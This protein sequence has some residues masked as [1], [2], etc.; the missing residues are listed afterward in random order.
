MKIYLKKQ[1]EWNFFLKNCAFLERF[2][3]RVQFTQKKN[4]LQV[5]ANKTLINFLKSA[6]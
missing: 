1:P 2:W 6:K 4:I 5:F 3:N